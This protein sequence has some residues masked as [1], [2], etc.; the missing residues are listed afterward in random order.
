[1]IRLDSHRG[2]KIAP[3]SIY[4]L[5]T[6][7][8]VMTV[9]KKYVYVVSREHYHFPPHENDMVASTPLLVFPKWTEA[10]A[11]A[12]GLAQDYGWKYD[13]Q[14]V[15]KGHGATSMKEYRVWVDSTNP[16]H[17]RFVWVVRKTELK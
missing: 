13:E 2:T 16:H 4:N 5:K 11:Y 14:A 12:H 10:A 8:H 7:V 1:M 6:G 3:Q 15:V 17:D 9:E